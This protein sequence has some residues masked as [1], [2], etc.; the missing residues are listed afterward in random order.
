MTILKLMFILKGLTELGM[1]FLFGQA[2]I[3]IFLLFLSQED[4]KNNFIYS[5]F[6][7]LTDPLKKMA[8]Y[9]APKTILDAHLGLLAFGLL[10]SFH[11]IMLTVVFPYTCALEGF[12][13]V[14]ECRSKG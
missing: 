2:M 3:W 12:Q 1:A 9:V 14:A 4:R 7:V 10:F 6:S 5:L 8:R 11:L 13:T